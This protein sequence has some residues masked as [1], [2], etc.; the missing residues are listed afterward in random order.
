MKTNLFVIV[1]VSAAFFASA[2]V[3][4]HAAE[5]PANQTA[6][7]KEMAAVEQ[8]LSLSD[9]E[10]EQMVLVIQRIRA[11][12]PDE[13][14]ALRQEVAKYCRLPDSQ[15]QQMRM[16]WGWMPREIQDGWR[17]MMQ[18]T[19]SERRAEIQSKLQSLSP[20]ERAVLRKQLVEEFL[21]QKAA[22]K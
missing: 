4:L 19:T 5:P 8:F 6:T 10:L 20:E 14:A 21:K 9:A 17:E 16:G 11:M 18:N 12:K 1:F 15:R 2:A 7:I 22:K 3:P 13:R